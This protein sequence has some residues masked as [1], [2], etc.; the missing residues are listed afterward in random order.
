VVPR[1]LLLIDEL[2]NWYIRFNRARLKGEGGPEDTITALNTL[3]EAL[4]TLCRTMVSVSS[5]ETTSS[6]SN[7]PKSSFTPFITENLY[8]TLR[9][10][11]PPTEKDNRSIHF[12]DFPTVNEKY[13]DPEIERQVRR[14]QAVIELTRT[15][16]EKY[17]PSLKVQSLFLL[18]PL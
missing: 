16:R 3:F 13:F 14:M 5:G 15:L 10:F 7:R 9:K 18:Y 11:L 17:Q 12:V 6:F 1:L 8:Q 4:Y 2:T